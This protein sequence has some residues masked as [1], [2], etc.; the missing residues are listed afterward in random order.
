MQDSV[1]IPAHGTSINVLGG[2]LF[3]FVPAESVVSLSA[4]GSVAGVRATLIAGTPLIQDQAINSNNRFPIIPDDVLLSEELAED[5]RLVLTFRNT[6][7]AAV[8]A[9]WRV[10]IE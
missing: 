9:F 2:Q 10:D 5:A 7:A 4:T 3:E 1:S 6:T 8:I